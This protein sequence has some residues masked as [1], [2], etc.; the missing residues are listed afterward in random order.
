MKGSTCLR[1]IQII[2]VC[3]RTALL[4]LLLLL[5]VRVWAAA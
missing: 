5:L 3:N 4:L 1:I 2:C